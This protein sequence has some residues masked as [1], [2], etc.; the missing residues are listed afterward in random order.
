MNRRHQSPIIPIRVGPEAETFYVHRAVL[1]KTE[2]FRKALDGHFQEAEQQAIDLPEEE[3][4]VFSFVVAFLYEG[5][6]QPI[7][8]VSE[9]LVVEPEK[10]KGK[11]TDGNESSSSSSLD[12]SD[13]DA[14]GSDDSA[15]SR[16]RMENRRRRQQRIWE[17]RNRKEPGR[18]RPDCTCATCT[19]DV[20]APP[21]WNC[22]MPRTRPP[23][24]PRQPPY[25]YNNGMPQP[26]PGQPMVLGIRP[27]PNVR[28]N[29]RNRRR[30]GGPRPPV[31]DF[32]PEPRM[33]DED[34]RSWFM[35][36]ELSIDV[37]VCA[38]RYLINELKDCVHESVI[39]QLETCGLQAAQPTVLNC[40]KKLHAGVQNNDVL[41]KKVFARVGF[42]LSRLWKAYPEETQAFWIENPELGALI[43]R[44]TMERREVDNGD[45]LPAMDRVLPRRPG[46]ILH[47]DVIMINERNHRNRGFR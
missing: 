25:W 22:S 17:E 5:M 39:D 47:D 19:I 32:M 9:V 4:A 30:G 10:G 15:R 46:P 21:C 44:E 40:C 37:Y 36:Y 35:A 41:L 26:P 7:K 33:S 45:H 27:M 16:R 18:H 29:D 13:S 42:M 1:M 23:P 20:H 38:E 11:E 12:V 8:P 6:F 28:P 2:Y 43:M 14:T 3:P 24:P 34:L 31:L